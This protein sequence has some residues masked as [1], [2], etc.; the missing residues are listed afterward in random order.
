MYKIDD[1]RDASLEDTQ[2]HIRHPVATAGKWISG[3]ASMMS[4]CVVGRW[5]RM[6]NGLCTVKKGGTG[7]MRLLRTAC[8]E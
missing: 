4:K 7:N 3:C 5:E 2:R 6:Q 8:C 1:I